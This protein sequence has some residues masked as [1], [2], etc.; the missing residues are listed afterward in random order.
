MARRQPPGINFE[1]QQSASPRIAFL[2]GA[3]AEPFTRPRVELCRYPIAVV[4]RQVRHALAPGQL[5]LDQ[6]VGVLGGAALPR[7]VWRGEVKAGADRLLDRRVAMELRAVV[8]GNRPDRAGLSSN[9]LVAR[10][11]ACVAGS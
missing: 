10:R 3:V 5:L 4:L 11:F 1:V 2:R 6:A 8:R 7:V 9:Q